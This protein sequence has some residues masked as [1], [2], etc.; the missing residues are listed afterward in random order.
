[1][2]VEADNPHLVVGDNGAQ[3]EDLG[4]QE[5]VQSWAMRH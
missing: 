5:W 2:V 4:Q 3:I 1:M